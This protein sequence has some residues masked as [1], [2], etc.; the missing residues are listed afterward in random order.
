ML[1]HQHASPQAP[2]RVVLLGSSGFLANSLTR[3]LQSVGIAYSAVGSRD[4]DLR[5]ASAAGKLG[6]LLQARD[7]L[8]IFSA[9]TPD[10][11]RDVRTLM[12]NLRMAESICE[13]LA[14][15]GCG[16]LV[17]VSSD[18]VY[19]A[20]L[21]LVD[22]QSSCEPTDLYALMH[23]ARERMLGS[24]AQACKIPYTVVR[25]CAVYGAR[26]THN[27]YGPNRFIR[28][29]IADGVIAL[30]GGGEER[31]DHIYADDVAR[32]LE[33]CLVNGSTGVVNAVSGYSVSFNEVARLVVGA[34][35]THVRIECKP[36][37]GPITHRH[38]D[39]SALAKAFPYF[40]PRPLEG[41]IAEAVAGM[42]MASL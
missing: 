19:D 30:F 28:T 18:A 33:L 26:D 3:R 36:R 11:G 4:V 22:E 29:A 24:V 14:A 5:D 17:Y 7:S 40:R 16:H 32:I 42:K 9:L 1:I 6:A 39:P 38:F 8:V 37:G 34:V 41:G 10:K 13:A 21:A 27:S 12:S 20:R 23:I 15:G 31:R 2:A 35:G 25:P